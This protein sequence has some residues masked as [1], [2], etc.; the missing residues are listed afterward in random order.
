MAV[1][2]KCVHYPNWGNR[3][4]G[5]IPMHDLE[6]WSRVTGTAWNLMV[7]S[8]ESGTKQKF[9]PSVMNMIGLTRE[10]KE[11]TLSPS[12]RGEQS[13]ECNVTV[14]KQMWSYIP[15]AGMVPVGKGEYCFCCTW[16]WWAL[17]RDT[18]TILVPSAPRR[19][20]WTDMEQRR[21]SRI[22]WRARGTR[23]KEQGLVQF[24]SRKI[25]VKRGWSCSL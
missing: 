15:S 21:T 25:E 20:I 11:L 2:V 18:V 5:N 7:Q 4:I 13:H 24:N 14:K 12:A 9:L 8:A 10:E 16:H 19:W 1:A 17:C 22:M 6:N 3:K 23:E